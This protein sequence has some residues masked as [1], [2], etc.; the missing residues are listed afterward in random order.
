MWGL[1]CRP[2]PPT[3]TTVTTA[4]ATVTVTNRRFRITH[5]V[6]RTYDTMRKYIRDYTLNPKSTVHDAILLNVS[7]RPRGLRNPQKHTH[8]SFISECN[9]TSISTTVALYQKQTN[10]YENQQAPPCLQKNFTHT[11]T[12]SISIANSSVCFASTFYHTKGFVFQEILRK[13][14]NGAPGQPCLATQDKPMLVC[15]RANAHLR[16]HET[17][18]KQKRTKSQP[19]KFVDDIKL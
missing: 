14:T 17:S 2:R 6:N 3:A 15:K 1:R 10:K 19:D 13:S 8:T 7:Q 18:C 12:V 5:S 16:R 4:M 9:A 11:G